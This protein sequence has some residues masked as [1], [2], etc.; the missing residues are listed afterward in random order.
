MKLLFFFLTTLVFLAGCAEREDKMPASVYVTIED[1]THQYAPG[2]NK[3]LPIA[4]K[5][6]G[7]AWQGE[8]Q[9]ALLQNDSVLQQWQQSYQ[10]AAD[11]SQLTQIEIQ[12]PQAEGVYHLQ[13]SIQNFANEPV[14]SRRLIEV[15]TPVRVKIN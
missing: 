10:A 9:L 1:F 8:I 13:A 14:L 15:K 5:T 12:L 11:T 6:Y 7:Q 3:S 4:I 2:S